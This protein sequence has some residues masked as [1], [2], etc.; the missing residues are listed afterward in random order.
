MDATALV[1]VDG[2]IVTTGGVTSG[3]DATLELVARDVG[4]D[5]ARL[6]AKWLVV[7]RHRPA[8]QSPFVASP[9]ASPSRNSALWPPAVRAM[10]G[11]GAPRSL[12]E[13][14][15]LCHV[16]ER[17]LRRLFHAE[18]GMAPFAYAERLRVTR[19]VEALETGDRRPLS[20]LAADAGFPD[21][22]TLRRA[23]RRIVGVSPHEFRRSFAA[24]TPDA[25]TA[26]AER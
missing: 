1:T 5:V 8:G 20:A 22:Q 16:S 17:Q 23:F 12:R 21:T 9:L 6:V 18:L 11:P 4:D 7:P 19:V 15:G 14:A 3:I 25:A 2:P 13:L 10:T 24:P 26:G